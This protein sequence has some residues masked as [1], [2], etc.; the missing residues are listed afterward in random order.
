MSEKVNSSNTPSSV[1]EGN[2]GD[3]LPLKANPSPKV[4]A[5]AERGEE[6]PKET[7]R[8]AVPNILSDFFI[9]GDFL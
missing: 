2:A 6:I 8:T 3:A 9:E 1:H 4:A 7:A 5:V